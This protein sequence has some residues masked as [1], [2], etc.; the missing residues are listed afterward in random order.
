V[1]T[2][3]ALFLRRRRSALASGEKYEVS[4][5]TTIVRIIAAAIIHM[6]EM[7]EF[8]CKKVGASHSAWT[9]HLLIRSNPGSFSTAFARRQHDV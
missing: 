6:I 9:G 8:I 1:L 2:T 7:S 4:A 3:G 5:P